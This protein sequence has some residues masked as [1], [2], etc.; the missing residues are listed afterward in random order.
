MLPSRGFENSSTS[1]RLVREVAQPK[2]DRHAIEAG[3][4]ERQALCVRD[5][6]GDLR[7]D[8]LVDQAVAAA[9]KH[10]SVDVGEHGEPVAPD[11]A[12]E[13]GAEIPGAA[14][15]V[16]RA[17]PGPQAR[18]QGAHVMPPG[19]RCRHPDSTGSP[20]RMPKQQRCKGGEVRRTPL[21]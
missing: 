15:D 21:I 20:S 7:P 2:P 5:H 9:C 4:R 10:L 8:T 17:L 12:R 16:E 19:G 11:L 6:Q 13:T 18:L 3:I 1:S 14:G